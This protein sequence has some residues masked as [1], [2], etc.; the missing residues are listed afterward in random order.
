MFQPKK[1]PLKFAENDIFI[2]MFIILET[3]SGLVFYNA[4]SLFS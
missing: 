1:C 2:F 3:I 4:K